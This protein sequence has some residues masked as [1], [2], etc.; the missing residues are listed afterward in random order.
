MPTNP[1]WNWIVLLHNQENKSIFTANNFLTWIYNR[2]TAGQ[3]SDT[4]S[5]AAVA[6]DGET[7]R[8]RPGDRKGSG[9]P[10]GGRRGRV[11]PGGTPKESGIWADEKEKREQKLK[12]DTKKEKKESIIIAYSP[13]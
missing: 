4:R 7:N 2:R 13:S 8:E 9:V 10:R 3:A 6:E 1:Q 11:V 12:E 5:T